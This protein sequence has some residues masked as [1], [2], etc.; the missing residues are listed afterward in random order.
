MQQLTMELKL[1]YLNTKDLYSLSF[2]NISF[3]YG[4]SFNMLSKT[5]DTPSPCNPPPIE[6]NNPKQINILAIIF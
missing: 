1:I 2:L 6:L 4:L 3:L 5:L